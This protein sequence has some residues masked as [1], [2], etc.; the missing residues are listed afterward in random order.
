MANRIHGLIRGESSASGTSS[1][2]EEQEQELNAEQL[3][4]AN[5]L[6]D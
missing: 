3:Q 5:S 4:N 6:F 2:E 1:A